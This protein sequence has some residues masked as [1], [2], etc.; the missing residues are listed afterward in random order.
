[1][2]ADVFRYIW[3]RLDVFGCV[4]L[5]FGVHGCVLIRSDGFG[6]MR[7]DVFGY[8]RICADACAGQ[9]LMVALW[10]SSNLV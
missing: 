3:M 9:M 7:S 4:Q 8:V 1:M 6:G 10:E 5:R 2:L